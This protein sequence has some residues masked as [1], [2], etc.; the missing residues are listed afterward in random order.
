MQILES[1]IGGLAFASGMAAITAVLSLFKSGD[2]IIIPS[3]LYGGTFR[4]IDKV[5]KNFKFNMKL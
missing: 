3:N 1:G 2:K 5:F 4:V